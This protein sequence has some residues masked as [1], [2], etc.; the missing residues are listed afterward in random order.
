MR[1]LWRF[2]ES[3]WPEGLGADL[4]PDP[5]VARGPA[6][7]AWMMGENPELWAL[8]CTDCH[9]RTGY[10]TPEAELLELY[11]VWPHVAALRATAVLDVSIDNPEI[12]SFMEKHASHTLQML[13]ESGSVH[14]LKKEVPSPKLERNI[15]AERLWK[16]VY[17]AAGVIDQYQTAIRTRP[18][19]IQE[20][21]CQSDP[22]R[23]ALTAL[24]TLAEGTGGAPEAP[25]E[26]RTMIRDRWKQARP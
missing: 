1:C 26:G 25:S 2:S 9:F 23:S 5:V 20:G 6:K 15:E 16:A 22:F 12:S 3:P 11:R 4:S 18:E 24:R 10:W 7:Y 13:N 14:G 8:E 21:F 19:L 17:F